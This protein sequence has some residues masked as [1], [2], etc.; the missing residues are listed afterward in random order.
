MGVVYITKYVGINC[1]HSWQA[2]KKR[3]SLIMAA[4]NY[5]FDL[6]ENKHI[7]SMIY[8]LS[9]NNFQAIESQNLMN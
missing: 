7:V 1:T 5:S 2:L 3:V 9:G 6:K 4:K 8:L